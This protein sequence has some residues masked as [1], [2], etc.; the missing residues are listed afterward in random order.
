VKDT[1][2]FSSGN[3]EA[4]M[5]PEVTDRNQGVRNNI[6]RSR[7][8]YPMST[9]MYF[10]LLLLLVFVPVLIV[11]CYITY[12]RF[13]TSVG[14][15]SQQNLEVARA[16]AKTFD[17]FVQD[18][19]HQ[20]YTIGLAIMQSPAWS[21]ED[22]CRFLEM[23]K[24]NQRA[25]REFVLT[26]PQGLITGASF[27]G[28]IGLSIFERP[29]FKEI[30]DGREW[31]VSDLITSRVKGD[32]IFA[33]SR[34]I[35]DDAGT[36]RGVI[37]AVVL[38]DGL[39][40]MLN[41]GRIGAGA[42]ATMDRQGVTVSRYPKVEW[43]W[44]KRA[45]VSQHP[46]VQ[47]SLKGKEATA[48]VPG[49]VHQE[50]RIASLTPISSIG[51]VAGAATPKA[52]ILSPII[53]DL[54]RHAAIFVVVALAAFLIAIFFSNVMLRSVRRLRD[55]AVALAHKEVHTVVPSGPTE[56]RDLAETM[57]RMAKE[58]RQWVDKAEALAAQ[59]E[60]RSRELETVLDAVPAGVMVADAA[61]RIL[62]TSAATQRIFGSPVTGDAHAPS[63]GYSLSTLDGQPIRPGQLPLS[64]ALAGQ[65]VADKELLITRGDGTQAIILAGAARL[66][67][68]DGK[69]L[70]AITMFQDI[71]ERKQAEKALRESEARFR[72][73]LRNAPV[74]VAAQDRDLRYIWA[75][76]QRT[77]LSDQIIGHFDHEIFT[78]EEAARIT[79]IKRRV[80]D[81]G[82]ELREQMWLDR[83][84]GVIFLDICWEPI[85]DEAGRIT[86]LASATVDLTPIK[87][88]EQQTAEREKE[89]RLVMNTVPAL[90]SYLDRE[91]HYRRVNAG[92]E[93][94][95]GE[96]HQDMEGRHVRDV[97]GEPAWQVARS[98]LERAMHGETVTYEEQM[99]YRAVGPRWIAATL[100][101]DRD[102]SGHVQGLV[103]LITDITER[104]RMEESLRK[105]RDEL[106]LRVQDRTAELETYMKRLQES[107]QALQDF[108]SIASHDMHEPLR[109]VMS[110]GDILK[111]EYGNAIGA[112]GADYL[113]RMLR[114][115][116]RMQSLLESLL[117][118]SRVTTRA[119]P[120][121]EV[122]LNGLV[123]EVLN[124]L[125][126]RIASTG[127]EVRAGELPTVEA[128]PTQMRQLFQN[129]IGN[130]LKFHKEGERPLV[131]VHWSSDDTRNFRIVVEDNGIGFEEKHLN[132]IFAPFQRLHGRSSQYEGSGMGLAI[133][134]KIIER[135]GGSI[136]AESEPGKGSRFTVE[137]PVKLNR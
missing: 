71:T 45:L 13:Q 131:K 128:D 62:M 120:F 44:E 110:F 72:L 5:S 91:F 104:K 98:R 14:Q 95:F 8:F 29:Y 107:N 115:T 94:W 50:D 24:R 73:A 65:T 41:V 118:Y 12:E 121:R 126:V 9:R 103:T 63:A 28:A 90:I 125:E 75:Y 64:L 39:D 52:E 119:E 130:A 133:C 36:L 58:I 78:P 38:P 99:P 53:A 85:R 4:G 96:R 7:R 60:R 113:D 1:R 33:I 80:L 83:P 22:I 100:V 76:N 57:N 114:A 122:D 70:G 123:Q 86:G 109:K 74:S 93:R 112:R 108:A 102:A 46:A 79:A 10:L 20:E 69:P 105:S 25:I 40:E 31:S 124:D 127:G 136:T 92:Y 34:G 16:A 54:T 89:L 51:W 87:L 66:L 21:T 82:I 129:L 97:L 49:A 48:I 32:P 2:E 61:G 111:A 15:E 35:R 6:E 134:K 81:E 3:S 11:Q 88:A 56:F 55:N 27:P 137:L 19:L 18:V 77:A 106:E 43:T 17:A 23:N 132:T 101:P 42:V 68:D 26:D 37:V 116:G 135:H 30:K 67:G 47:E 59:T 84:G 117:D